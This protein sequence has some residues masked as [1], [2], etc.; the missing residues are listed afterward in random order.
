[1]YAFDEIKKAD[2]EIADA[3][4][5]EMERQNSH[6]EL[7]ASEN[8][9]SK[10]VMAAMGSPLTNKYAEGYPGKRY[11][12]GCQCVDV[13][14]DL[15]RERAKKLFGCDYAN[16]Q[17][18]SGA[19]A[20]LA[21][22]F[23]MLEPGD[24]VM[25]MNLDHGGHLTHGSPVNIS[26]KYF[27]VVSYGVNDEGVIDYDKV[28][29]IAVKEKPKMIIAGASAYARTIDFKKFR[30]IADEVGAYLMVDMAHI[31]GLVAAG[32]H[33]SPIPYA[34]VTTTTTHKTLRGPRGGLILCNQEAADKF[35]FNKAVFP[36]IQGG[37]LEHVIAGKAVC[38]KEA[39]E[40][41]F[42][43]Y[44]KQIIKN[45]QALSK[46][47]MDRGVKI[48]SGGTD[49]HLMLIDLRGEDVTG[50]EL[51][52]RLDAAHITC[53]KNTVPNDPR[54][55]FVTSGVRLGTPAVTTRGLK[56]EDM[57]VIAECIALVLQSEDNIEKVKGMVAELTAKYPLDM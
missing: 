11:Y 12:G 48:V 50:K 6:L 44:Q 24:K 8:W 42:A 4:Q 1:M 3:I 27:N 49:N 37:P 23:A 28:R 29:E 54:S 33:P 45:A 10:A 35:N 51:E 53:N 26:G 56:E 5:A 43:E 34:D 41:E 7:I 2:S 39:L 25:G 21:V 55:P 22:F 52:K 40:P 19:Q 57:D 36:G 18:H 46:G 13:V 38:F 20:N 9:V 14:E 17:P 47:L 30:E 31:A 16:V 32:L 15:A